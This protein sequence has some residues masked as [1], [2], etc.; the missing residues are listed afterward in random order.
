MHLEMQR[1]CYRAGLA[2]SLPNVN[3]CIHHTK[4]STLLRN[5]IF[6]LLQCNKLLGQSGEA[7]NKP[8]TETLR[9]SRNRQK[10]KIIELENNNF[11]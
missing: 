4:K 10:V 6:I 1:L 3:K 7:G 11:I 5:T 9:L 2:C 8:I